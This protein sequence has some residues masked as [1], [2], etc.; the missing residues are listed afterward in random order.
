MREMRTRQ[1]EGIRLAV[2][3]FT[4]FHFL[5]FLICFALA[6]SIWKFL[7]QILNQ[8]HS[9]YPSCCSDNSGSL[10]ALPLEFPF[11]YV[12]LA[13]SIWKFPGQGSNMSHSSDN[14]ESLTARPPRNS[15]FFSF[16][17][18]GGIPLSNF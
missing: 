9:S 16:F 18:W 1:V 11:A 14:A 13:C 17:F 4:V 15:T 10:P 3:P 12:F 7:G 8:C 6:Q 2:K 5:G